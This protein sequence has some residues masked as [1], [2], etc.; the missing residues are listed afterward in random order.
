MR[1]GGCTPFLWKRPHHRPG[2]A[3][4]ALC[5]RG[6]EKRRLGEDTIRTL[7]SKAGYGK[8][9]RGRRYQS[10]WATPDRHAT[11]AAGALRSLA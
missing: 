3:F 4:S 7:T 2:C 1:G 10:R 9:V 5:N 8:Q 11:V 6:G